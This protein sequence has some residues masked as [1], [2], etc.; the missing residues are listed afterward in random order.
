M[1]IIRK[2]AEKYGGTV[3]FEKK[4]EEFEVSFVLFGV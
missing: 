4:E 3:S 1:K 2:T